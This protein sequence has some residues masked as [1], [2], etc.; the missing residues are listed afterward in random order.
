MANKSLEERVEKLEKR[1]KVLEAALANK[2]EINVVTLT[3]Y[4]P[5]VITPMVDPYGMP[6]P[7]C[8]IC[9]V[10]SHNP[11]FVCTNPTCPTRHTTTC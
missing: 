1:I 7:Q 2:A 6:K 3:P 4:I 8:S 5:P 9:L 11:G 10:N